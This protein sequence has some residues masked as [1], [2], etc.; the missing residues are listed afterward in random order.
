MVLF[1]DNLCGEFLWVTENDNA[2]MVRINI[3]D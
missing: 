1:D 2:K 3:K